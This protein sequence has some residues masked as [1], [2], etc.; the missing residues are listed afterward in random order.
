MLVSCMFTLLS[1]DYT[2]QLLLAKP[3]QLNAK[4]SLPQRFS[5]LFRRKKIETGAVLNSLPPSIKCK[6]ARQGENFQND[7]NSSISIPRSL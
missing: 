6:D 7:F 1:Y 3:S 2:V 5:L 4:S